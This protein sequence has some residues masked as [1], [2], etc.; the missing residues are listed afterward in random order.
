MITFPLTTAG[1]TALQQ[2]LNRRLRVD[3]PA[4]ADRIQKAIADESNLAENSEYHAALAD[5]QINEARILELEHQLAV[6]QIVG[7]PESD[8]LHG[9]ISV[10]SP[11]G[12]ALA[13]KKARLLKSSR[14]PGSKPS[15]SKRSNGAQRTRSYVGHPTGLAFSDSLLNFFARPALRA[16]WRRFARRSI[17]CLGSRRRRP[18]NS[19]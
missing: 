13:R 5:Q 1:H 15:K 10:N 6:W 3:R 19:R 14:Q 16:A 4:L 8:V 9:K 17:L 2:G 7:E 12:R 18:K 11:I